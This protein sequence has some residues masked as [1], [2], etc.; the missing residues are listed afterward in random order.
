MTIYPTQQL[1]MTRNQTSLILF[2]ILFVVTVHTLKAQ[3]PNA[4]LY[5]TATNASGTGTLSYL[6]NDLNWMASKTGSVGP[7]SPCKVLGQQSIWSPSPF[8]NASWISYN[9]TCTAVPG[10]HICDTTHI[11]EYYRL[12]LNLPS[13]ICGMAITTPSTYCLDLDFLADNCVTN[14][15][16]NGMQSYSIAIPSPY[17]YNG[18]DMVNKTAVSLCDNWTAGTNTL[19]VHIKSGALVP[20]DLVGFLA[21][22]N[23]TLNPGVGKGILTTGYTKTEACSWTAPGS[24][25]IA[26]PAWGTAPYSYS[27]TPTGGTAN[28]SGPLLPGN[29]TCTVKTP[30]SGTCYYKVAINGPASPTIAVKKNWICKDEPCVLIA[31]GGPTYTWSTLQQGDTITVPNIPLGTNHFTVT[32]SYSSPCPGLRTATC[33]VIVSSCYG[34]KELKETSDFDWHVFPNPGNTHIFITTS[35]LTYLSLTDQNGGEVLRIRLDGA[36]QYE[37]D[38]SLLP[39]GLYIAHLQSAR[40]MA[41]K[42]IVI[43]K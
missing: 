29:Y 24:A 17:S 42:K 5:N 9:H 35:S 20:G 19:I 25:T 22:A 13:Q 32:S 4:S 40:G 41:S 37:E 28:I 21:Q 18:F 16:V 27:W 39:E 2:L 1:V 26:T 3:L 30:S 11:D 31:S 43:Q 38:L 10:E 14:I 33:S 34:I 8:V 23:Q 15:F 12:I 7:Y 6:S 36:K